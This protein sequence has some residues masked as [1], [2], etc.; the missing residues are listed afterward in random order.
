MPVVKLEPPSY[1]VIK[2]DPNDV[3]PPPPADDR[4]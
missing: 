1:K 2:I 3:P 4:A